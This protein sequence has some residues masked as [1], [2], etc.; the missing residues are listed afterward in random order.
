MDTYQDELLAA[1]KKR[2]RTP[3]KSILTD[4]KDLYAGGESKFA[5]CHQ[6]T[7]E[8]EAKVKE[9]TK[10]TIRCIPLEHDGEEGACMVTGKPSKQRVIF[11]KSY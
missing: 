9:E 5:W 1:A 3:L 4:F 10:C 11:A 8:T 6:R 7:A 2:L